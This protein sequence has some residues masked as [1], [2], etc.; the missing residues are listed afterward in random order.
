M[1]C[2]AHYISCSMLM[3]PHTCQFLHFARAAYDT[4][5]VKTSLSK[6]PAKQISRRQSQTI[7]RHSL[8]L[9]FCFVR[10]RPAMISL[11][12]ATLVM[13][14]ATGRT[15]S[16]R[17]RLLPPTSIQRDPATSNA[18]LHSVCA[19]PLRPSRGFLP[20]RFAHADHQCAPRYNLGSASANLRKRRHATLARRHSA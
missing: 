20:W 1:G 8:V 18:E 12:C 16:S 10:S 7:E 5:T 17:L 6:K 15:A 9:P 4:G 11:G 13:P 19:R 2:R 3:L 14:I